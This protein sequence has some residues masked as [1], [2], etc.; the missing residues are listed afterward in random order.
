VELLQKTKT[1]YLC[2]AFIRYPLF[3]VGAADYL[4]FNEFL[5]LRYSNRHNPSHTTATPTQTTRHVIQGKFR[6]FTYNTFYIFMFIIYDYK[7]FTI[8]II[9]S[10]FPQDTTRNGLKATLDALYTQECHGDIIDIKLLTAVY[11]TGLF[12]MI[13]GVLTTCHTQYT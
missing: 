1:S 9:N 12:E 6:H 10:I 11:N 3:T 13:V 2:L 4:L 5:E 7:N 8:Q